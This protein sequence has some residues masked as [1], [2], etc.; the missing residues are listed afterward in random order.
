MIYLVSYTHN[1][2]L[3]NILYNL[4]FFYLTLDEIFFLY[5]G[6]RNV[7]LKRLA[8]SL[9]IFALAL[10]PGSNDYAFS[11]QGTYYSIHL[12]TFK[13]VDEARAKVK[14][15][16]DRGYN[17]FYRR[18]KS[19]DN[20]VEFAVY[21][22]RFNSRPEA[23]KEAN[24]L[25]E[26]NLISDYDVREI[27]EKTKTDSIRDSREV[28]E[29][30]RINSTAPEPEA[31]RKT[32]KK[33]AVKSETTKKSDSRNAR[34]QDV[35]SYYLKVSSLKEKANAE[36]T[37]KI[38]KDAGYHAF[39][40]FENIKGKGDWYRVYLD[41]YQSREDAEK[42][43]K[44]LMTS[45]I[46]AG[47][48]IKRATGVIQPAEQA[49]KDDKKIYYL[50]VA[51]FKDAAHADEEVRRLTESGL[52]AVSKNAEVSGEQWFRVYIGEFSDEKEA[53]EKGT[54]L[55]QNGVI[56]YFKPMLIQ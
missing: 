49:Q 37:V 17:A 20:A 52:K 25:K 2:N 29:K 9:F 48:E 27:S 38:L 43:A 42:D 44:K 36:E 18:E 22:E 31:V 14:D 32:E 40:N 33:S 10:M 28:T 35:K 34:K 50:H 11:D 56:S 8:F 12:L 45:G 46:I 1:T 16:K 4:V 5:R 47:Y 51:S 55:V 13:T 54:E 23:D 39:Y 19:G 26:L 21:I 6:P 7:P 3:I 15:Y 41:T 30:A 53:R 24:I